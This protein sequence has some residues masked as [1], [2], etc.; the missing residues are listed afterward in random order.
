MSSPAT[1]RALPHESL[2]MLT[3]A[4]TETCEDQ[5]VV[6]PPENAIWL[7]SI[8]DQFE[9]PLLRYAQRITG[10]LERA[11]DVV[12][13]TFLRACREDRAALDGHLARWL[14]RVCRNRALDVQRKEQRM[15]V[16]TDLDLHSLPGGA[17]PDDLLAA[18]E[19]SSRLLDLL[20]RLPAN[21]QEVIRLKF[22]NELKYR[23]I[24][25]ITSQSIATVGFL[26]H[27]GLKRLREL[28]KE[29]AA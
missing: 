1:A 29:D 19:T 3:S 8:L 24:A 27:T 5:P 4:P 15:S 11:R 9:G 25:E 16:A 22:Q 13:E 20:E 26:L 23:E 17:G 21:Q 10:D 12:Q 7:Q 2:V 14:F 6:H 18:R 28:M